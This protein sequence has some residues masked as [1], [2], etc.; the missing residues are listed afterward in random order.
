ME[1]SGPLFCGRIPEYVSRIL[2]TRN[3]EFIGNRTG[4]GIFRGE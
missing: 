3:F 1:R 4:E 2:A